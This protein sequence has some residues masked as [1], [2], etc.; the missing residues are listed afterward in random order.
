MSEY[1]FKTMPQPCVQDEDII[2]PFCPSQKCLQAFVLINVTRTPHAMGRE[3]EGGRLKVLISRTKRHLVFT[4]K[5]SII[6]V[7]GSPQK[8]N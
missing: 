1:H 6:F 8:T 4:F 3:K 5:K 7:A 2:S